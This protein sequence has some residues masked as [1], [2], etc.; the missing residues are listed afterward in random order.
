MFVVSVFDLEGSKKAEFEVTDR[1]DD[2]SL[3]DLT[4]GYSAVFFDFEGDQWA[5]SG[6]VVGY[7]TVAKQKEAE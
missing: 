3:L 2:Q 4:S 6:S 7:V 5:F 1:P